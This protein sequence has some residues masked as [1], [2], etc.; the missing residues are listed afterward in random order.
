MRH[1]AGNK[2]AEH[3]TDEYKQLMHARNE[4]LALLALLRTKLLTP[5]EADTFVDARARLKIAQ[6]KLRALRR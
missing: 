4:D 3:Q 2:K 6:M 1:F 5:E